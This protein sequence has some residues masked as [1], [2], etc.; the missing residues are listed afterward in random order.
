VQA[1]FLAARKLYADLGFV[2]AEPIS[3]N[4]VPGASFLGLDL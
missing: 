2:P 3:F 4:P 1:K